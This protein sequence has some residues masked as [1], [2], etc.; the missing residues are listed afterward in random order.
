MKRFSVIFAAAAILSL[1]AAAALAGEGHC[2]ASTQECLDGMAA[3]LSSYGW[4]GLEG[5]YDKEKGQFTVTA[6]VASSPAYEAGLMEGDVVFGINDTYF[7]KMGEEDWAAS[8][9]ERVPGATA[10]Y[11]FKRDG[12]KKEAAVV[13][14]AMPEDMQLAKIGKHMIDHAEVA[15]VQ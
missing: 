15:S 13:L 4:A 8:K 1:S 11:M 3:N 7:A 6:I 14:A 5:D 2:T 10:N 9:A 12:Q